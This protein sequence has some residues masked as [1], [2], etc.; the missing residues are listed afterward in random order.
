MLRERE[1]AAGWLRGAASARRQHPSWRVPRDLEP[2]H[3]AAGF[4]R[5]R[6]MRRVWQGGRGQDGWASRGSSRPSAGQAGAGRAGG[7]GV[8]QPGTLRRGGSARARCACQWRTLAV[9]QGAWFR[10]CTAP[11]M[12]EREGLPGPCSARDSE[13]GPGRF[14]VNCTRPRDTRRLTRMQTHAIPPLRF[15]SRAR[16]LPSTSCRFGSAAGAIRRARRS[17]ARSTPPSHPR[18]QLQRQ[19]RPSRPRDPVEV[20]LSRRAFRLPVQPWPSPPNHCML[21]MLSSL[22]PNRRHTTSMTSSSHHLRRHL[23]IS[24]PKTN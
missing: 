22:P 13:S 3:R 15:Y 21:T 12:L 24:P 16:D 9:P 8:G 19:S 23:P 11:G 5:H 17:R 7:S 2:G 20:Q 1:S 18:S 10:E 4:T 6:R 14:S